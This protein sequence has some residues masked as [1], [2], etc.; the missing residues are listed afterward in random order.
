MTDDI[1]PVQ[2]RLCFSRGF[3][4]KYSFLQSR[5]SALVYFSGQSRKVGWAGVLSWYACEAEESKQSSRFPHFCCLTITALVWVLRCWGLF[6]LKFLL[7]LHTSRW[8]E[9]PPPNLTMSLNEV[10]RL[11]LTRFQT[12]ICTAKPGHDP[13]AKAKSSHVSS[14][15]SYCAWTLSVTVHLSVNVKTTTQDGCNMM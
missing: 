12:T 4:R 13:N 10:V 9:T 11:R 2:L 3:S 14:M 5:F 8:K 6:Y 1:R 7:K 15:W